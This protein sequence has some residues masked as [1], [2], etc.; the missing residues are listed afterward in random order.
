M[1]RVFGC[2]LVVATEPGVQDPLEE[3]ARVIRTAVEEIRL[4]KAQGVI[5]PVEVDGQFQG[6]FAPGSEQVGII[7]S[8][9]RRHGEQ[10]HRPDRIT[11][12][13]PSC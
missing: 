12:L 1:A 8:R 10:F 13:G 5:D 11:P 2:C 7:P 3:I 9:H 4:G 6:A